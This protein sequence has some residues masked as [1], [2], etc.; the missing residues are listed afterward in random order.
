MPSSVTLKGVLVFCRSNLSD[1]DFF[2]LPF[3]SAQNCAKK[4][5]CGGWKDN[6]CKE[7]CKSNDFLNGPFQASFS[8]IFVFSI[9]LTVNKCS[10]YN[11]L[12]MTRFEP[13]TSGIGSACSINWATTT[14]RWNK[15]YL[16]EI[17]RHLKLFFWGV[18]FKVNTFSHLP[19]V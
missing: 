19:I 14:A 15:C 4:I 12:P 17:F 18:P 10:I 1:V 7:C 6:Q 5:I 11:F 3:L 16:L 9:Q 13:W 8:F 2:T